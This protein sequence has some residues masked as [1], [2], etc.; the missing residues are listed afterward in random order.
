MRN[1]GLIGKKALPAGS[2]KED[3]EEERAGWGD[4]NEELLCCIL[5]R[6]D[7]MGDEVSFECVCKP[8]KL[9]AARRMPP[10]QAALASHHDSPPALDSAPYLMYLNHRTGRFNFHDPTRRGATYSVR[11][12]ELLGDYPGEVECYY[13]SCGWLLLRKGP[14]TYFLFNP[15]TM[16]RIDLPPVRDMP[17]SFES[18]CFSGSP[19]S[20]SCRIVGF[21]S[22]VPEQVAFIG[23]TMVG[24][25]SWS[26][27]ANTSNP[28]DF[29]ASI[30]P[31][32][33]CDGSFYVLGESGNLGCLW[34][35]PPKKGLT[36]V[37]WEVIGKPADELFETFKDQFLLESDGDIM[38]VATLQGGGKVCV[39]KLDPHTQVW[40]KV[41]DLQG[42]ALYVSQSASF[43]QK[44][45]SRGTGNKIY[46][47]RFY[48]NR[49]LF[50]CL[51]TKEWRNFP[52]T[53]SSTNYY[54]TSALLHSAWIG[55]SPHHNS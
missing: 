24:C 46:F 42:K 26:V 20:S 47:P 23:E 28:D 13:A 22:Y 55:L 11:I 6:L 40:Q 45:V 27:F 31:P 35:R 37:S 43:S 19:T 36:E 9:A 14:K 17:I 39:L 12:P 10:P 18:M 50:Y 1:L 52:H 16:D 8:W 41:D 49:G 5:S 34:F 54:N 44:A 32:I 7:V 2:R 21:V 25:D 38:C 30:C 15:S 51:G 48:N 33:V 53:F 29:V 4:L 3:E